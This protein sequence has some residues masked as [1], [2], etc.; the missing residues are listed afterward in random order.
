MKISAIRTQKPYVHGTITFPKTIGVDY[1]LKNT[2]NDLS[3][4][5]IQVYRQNGY[6]YAINIGTKKEAFS[7]HIEPLTKEVRYGSGL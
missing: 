7:L 4:A 3:A 6:I 1:H 2:M 5:E